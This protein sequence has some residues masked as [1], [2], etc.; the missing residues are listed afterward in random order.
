M[1]FTEHAGKAA[2]R[3]AG[4]PTP[5]GIVA[6]TPEDVADAARRIGKCVIKAQV[7]TGKRGKA[8]G[9]KLATTPEEAANH[10]RAI[11][12]MTIG[13]HKVDHVLVDPQVN[14]AREMYAAVLNDP[15]T[16]GPLLLFSPEGGMDIEEIAAEHPHALLRLP[17]S[18]IKGLDEEALAAA[19]RRYDPPA[20]GAITD[21]LVK[22]YEAYRASDAEL[23]E[24]NPLVQMRDGH[25]IALDCKL[26]VDDSAL[27][28]QEALAHS[29][30]PDK[31]TDLEARAKA[32]HLKYIELDG[33]VGVLANGAGLTMTTMDAIRHFGGQP[34]NFMEIGGD[35]YTKAVP[36]LEIVL[37]NPNVKALLVN[38]C[39]AFAR[40]DVMAEGV[41]N[42]WLHLKPKIPIVF[43]I[44]GTG[45]DEA[46][47]MVR[48]RLGIEP[49]DLMDDAVKA[50]VAAAKGARA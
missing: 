50:A 36:A 15:E 37:A 13:E 27:T 21:I 25:F 39:G 24:I 23:V 5:E 4:I 45:E 22:L 6:R 3:A 12:G 30:T 20:A 9:I 31:T 28:R 38:F 29:G 7:L 47:A 26:T 14:I 1:N 16:Q 34:A 41:I 43:T 10:A 42:A 11:L 40:T 35:S 18:I 46:I 8:G 19:V 32:L 44:H 17:I 48:E 2:L 33:E 49:H